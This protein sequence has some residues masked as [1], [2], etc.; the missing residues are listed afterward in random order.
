MFVIKAVKLRKAVIC[1]KRINHIV[2]RL[3]EVTTVEVW[4][5]PGRIK[6][7]PPVVFSVGGAIIVREFQ[8]PDHLIVDI[9]ILLHEDVCVVGIA[10]KLPAVQDT[11]GILKSLLE[12]RMVDVDQLMIVIL[13]IRHPEQ[14]IDKKAFCSVLCCP[15]QIT[16]NRWQVLR[17]EEHTS[18]LQSRGHLV[19]RL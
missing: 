10:L 6:S 13:F 14:G 8:L 19:C 1:F 2:G 15:S 5:P 4:I 9:V 18:E 7:V 16:L 3:M 12:T 17:S 11:V